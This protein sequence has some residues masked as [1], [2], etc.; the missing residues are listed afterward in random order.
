MLLLISNIWFSLIVPGQKFI[1]KITENGVEVTRIIALLC[2]LLKILRRPVCIRSGNIDCF[3]VG[4]VNRCGPCDRKINWFIFALTVFIGSLCW[5][6][7]LISFGDHVSAS[8]SANRP[9]PKSGTKREA[10]RKK[11]RQD[12]DCVRAH[13][14][15]VRIT[16]YD[17]CF[18]VEIWALYAHRLDGL[19]LLT[20]PSWRW[21]SIAF[22]K[23]LHI[24]SLSS[25]WS[26]MMHVAPD[27][28]LMRYNDAQSAD[29]GTTHSNSHRVILWTGVFFL[30]FFSPNIIKIKTNQKPHRA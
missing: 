3:V 19:A 20:G 13:Q 17:S 6:V 5:C 14:E 23:T 26:V 30:L 2:A 28:H 27:Q 18:I 11:K 25:M 9:E 12:Q 10:E 8:L 29:T 21:Y 24:R 1:I 7:S 22:N 4:A 16:I 15:A